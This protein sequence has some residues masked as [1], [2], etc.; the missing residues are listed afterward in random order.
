MGAE[1]GADRDRTS[2][3]E[4]REAQGC[5]E[6]GYHR[7]AVS[8][9]VGGGQA[10]IGLGARL[11]QLGCPRSSSTRA[12]GPATSGAAVTRPRR[13][14]DPVWHDDMPYLPFPE[15]WPV[16]SPKDKIADWL[17]PYTGE[18]HGAQLLGEHRGEER[19]LQR[20][21][22]RVDGQRRAGRP[23]DGAA[24]PAARAGH[25]DVRAAERPV[26]PG[27]GGIPRVSASL[28]GPSRPWERGTRA[29]G[30]WS[31]GRTTPPSTSAAR[32]GRPVP[33]SRWCSGRPL[34][35]RDP[36]R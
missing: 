11:R 13:L 18:D 33:T 7:A 32:C 34:T 21:H 16:F 2:W 10:G 23:G 27:H 9:I 1:H 29:S 15:N 31:S 36:T 20:G 12:T 22:R 8:L 26:L 5:R 24:P 19:V 30:A 3:M 4:N 14:H 17:E 35:S 6:L 28:L 25:R